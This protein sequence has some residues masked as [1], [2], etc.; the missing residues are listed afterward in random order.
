MDVYNN[1]AK[2]YFKSLEQCS[3][4]EKKGLNFFLMAYHLQLKNGETHL[5]CEDVV[6]YQV[7]IY[8][9]HT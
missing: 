5:K 9:C 6:L 4:R 3:V 2:W 1:S 8:F 7:M